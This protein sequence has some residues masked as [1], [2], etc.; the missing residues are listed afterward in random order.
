MEG[1]K[2]KQGGG[3]RWGFGG[4]ARGGRFGVG[5]NPVKFDGLSKYKLSVKTGRVILWAE[6]KGNNKVL[7]K[8]HSHRNYPHIKFGPADNFYWYK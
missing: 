1:I 2:I 6:E 5:G 7:S 8:L 4:L 3:G